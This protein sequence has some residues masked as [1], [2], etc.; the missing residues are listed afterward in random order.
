[1]LICDF[2]EFIPMTMIFIEV[3]LGRITLGSISC[4]AL[5][6]YSANF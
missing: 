3:G 2:F 4:H 1:M 6:S 5:D